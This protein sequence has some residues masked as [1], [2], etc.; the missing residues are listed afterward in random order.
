MD[1]YLASAALGGATKAIARAPSKPQRG[2]GRQNWPSRKVNGLICTRFSRRV[3]I[4][5]VVR[6]HFC[7]FPDFNTYPFASIL[8]KET[9]PRHDTAEYKFSTTP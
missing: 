2:L 6:V 8:T 9:P 3:I 5:C 4:S 7:P 1:A